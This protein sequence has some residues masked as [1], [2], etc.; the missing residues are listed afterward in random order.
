MTDLPARRPYQDEAV[1]QAVS[2]GSLLL[3][4]TMGAGK[5]RT[6][7]D[8]VE[9]LV[10]LGKVS[11]GS[12]FVLNS[13]KFQWKRE[14][15]QWTSGASVQVIDGPKKQRTAQYRAAHRYRYNV[16]NYECLIH[17][18]EVIQEY[19][20]IDFII[21][22][23]VTSI[24]SFHAKKSRR[25]KKLGKHSPYRF[26]LSGQPIEN[27]PEELFSI[28][29]FVNPSVLG[30]F[31]KFDRTFISR[32]HWGRPKFYRNLDLLSDSLSTAMFRRSRED[33]AEFLPKIIEVETFIQLDS[34]SQKLYDSIA[35]NL[36]EIIETA[37][38][39]GVGGFDLFSNYGR[40]DFNADNPF[41]GM[42][43][44]R[45]AVMRMLC[46]H[47]ALVLKSATD[48]DDDDTFGGSAY[49]SEL[50]VSG[51][52]D[53]LPPSSHKLECL[54]ETL[55][56]ILEESP[57]NKVVVFSGFKAMLGIIGAEASKRRWGWTLLSGDV[58]SEE[59]DRRIVL[60]NNDPK[61]RL[62]L[63]SD[64]GAYGVNL[65]AG[66]HLI[67]YDLPWSAG[68]FAQRVARIDRLSTKHENI[69]VES[70]F[71]QGTIE[72]RQYEMLCEK[73]KVGEA[74]IDG[75]HSTEGRFDLSLDSLRNF[76][77]RS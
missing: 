73:R 16:L 28:M 66:T 64:A 21:A 34:W 20:P 27:R 54:L 67:S 58:P 25:L 10:G 3:A 29:E 38:A 30:R 2:Q 56:T 5:T 62:F 31:D 18:W 43:M 59:R 14:I 4:M 77:L 55:H 74:F 40:G 41:Q 76:L 71:C 65:D 23:E 24:K 36:V 12:V 6:A 7:I 15:E 33:I 32:D 51:R 9:E 50:R 49:A 42:I 57:E 69:V 44:S 26:G 52:L 35:E 60:F 8:S 61:C 48:F 22:D 68:K 19:L 63:S 47:P 45:I 17:D 70:M 37:V 39:A 72:E 1:S 75:K 13:T 53:R 46:D 11:S